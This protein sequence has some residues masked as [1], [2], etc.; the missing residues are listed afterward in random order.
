MLVYLRNISPQ[1]VVHSATEIEVAD[2]TCY[3]TKSL[4]TDSGP[5]SPST[6]PVTPEAGQGGH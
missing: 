5:T 3:L 1:T 6:D 4:Y 2:Q